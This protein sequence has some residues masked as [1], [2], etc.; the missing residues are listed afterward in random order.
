MRYR[1]F[2]E[3]RAALAQELGHRP[4]EEIWD[5]LFEKDYV[6]E[7]WE[8]TAGI[9][10]LAEE[11]RKFARI[12]EPLLQPSQSATKSRP[13]QVRLQVLSDLIARQAAA[14]QVVVAF[15]RQHLTEGLL[16]HE[17]VD[18]WITK[19]ADEDGPASHYLTIPVPEDHELTQTNGRVFA[20]P[21]LTVSV[22]NPATQ[23][24][25]E[26]LA[27]ASAHDQWVR[28]IA[29]RHGGTLDRLRKLS[30]SLARRFKW[31][32]A[33]A[34]TF[35]LTGSSPPV[36]QFPR[37]VSLG[38]APAY[39]KSHNDG[40]RSDTYTA[41]GCRTLQTTSRLLNRCPISPDECEASEVGRVLRGPQT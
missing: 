30:E 28:R 19:Q 7:V 26:I 9:D 15:R 27:Y 25:V 37:W 41:G 17:E 12:P 5:L 11:Y 35:V 18:A 32:E 22:K 13:R 23:V 29:V 21:P 24:K 10:N 20:Q 8:E 34:A 14:E 39:F 3:I 38:V 36:V 4:S 6:R 40:N 16:R 33:H 2:D 1:S 31:H